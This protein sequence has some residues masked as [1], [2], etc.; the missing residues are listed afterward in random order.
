L[1]VI[2]GINISALDSCQLISIAAA[3]AAAAAAP[4]CTTTQPVKP[5][6]PKTVWTPGNIAGLAIGMAAAFGLVVGV[7]VFLLL[8]WHKS[9]HPTAAAAAAEPHK[10]DCASETSSQQTRVSVLLCD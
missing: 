5:A 9:R 3:A 2:T 1:A 10:S 4:A 7:V 8:R 6:Q